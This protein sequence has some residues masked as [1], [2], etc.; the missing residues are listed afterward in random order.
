MYISTDA[1]YTEEGTYS[2]NQNQTIGGKNAHLELHLQ[3]C[4]QQEVTDLKTYIFYKDKNLSQDKSKI[5]TTLYRLTL[6][7]RE[8]TASKASL[9]ASHK[10]ISANQ[11]SLKAR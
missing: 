6:M 11:A 2:Q 9:E 10:D 8:L 4:L 1:I 3:K 7:L 5:S